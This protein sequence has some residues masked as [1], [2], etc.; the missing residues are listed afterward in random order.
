[1]Q[2]SP[3]AWIGA[4]SAG[5]LR[6]PDARPSAS[7]LYAPRGVWL[8][9]RRLV[10]VD[11]GNHRVLLWFHRPET[12]HQPA[13]VV[14]GQ[15]A[16]DREGPRASGES[17]RIGMHLPTGVTVS[18][19]GRLFVADAWHHRV[20]VWNAWPERHGA[21]PDMV[22]GQ[23]DGESV[24]PNGGGP[25]SASAFYWPYGVACIGRRLLVADTGNRRVLI[26]NDIPEPGRPADVVLGQDDPTL[27]IENRGGPPTARSFRW[28]H[29]FAG[30]ARELLIAD[31][32]NHR[33]LGWSPWPEADA[34]AQTVLGQVDFTTNREF[35]YV[36]QSAR[37]LRFPYGVAADAHTMVVAD[38]ANN[39]ILVWPRRSGVRAAD[40]TLALGQADLESNGENRWTRVAPDTL[41]W[42]YGVALHGEI[43]AVADS[44]N[45]RVMLW[46]LQQPS[47]ARTA[48]RAEAT[49]A[50]ERSQPQCV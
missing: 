7:R 28:P 24:S 33:V 16:F 41:C 14:L 35:P 31:A 44:G 23:P 27:A 38:T 32:G 22:L 40:A 5:G 18:G 9:D 11:S 8:D 43:L 48:D 3:L 12:D 20:L 17:A 49:G 50:I 36:R 42:P 15:S 34:D 45:N 26:W 10:V 29:A 4:S 19:D 37:S 13:D 47:G 2:A 25:V 21:P 1:M 6:L 46:R 30:D 39:R